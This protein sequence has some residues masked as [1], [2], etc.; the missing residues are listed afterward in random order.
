MNTMAE[1]AENVVQLLWEDV[2][3][4]G[5]SSGF[6]QRRRKFDGTI[7]ARMMVCRALGELQLSYTHLTQ[8]AIVAPGYQTITRTATVRANRQR[9]YL[10]PLLQE[11]VHES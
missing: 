3:E 5:R 1:I 6:I 7:Y 10:P 9:I 11:Y 2:D 8:H 4:L